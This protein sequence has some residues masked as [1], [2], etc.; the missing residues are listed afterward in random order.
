MVSPSTGAWGYICGAPTL[1]VRMP[2]NLAHTG[3]SIHP[4]VFAH[5]GPER[6]EA[7]RGH[8]LAHPSA[9]G[10]LAHISAPRALE[11]GASTQRNKMRHV[12]S[13][14]NVIRLLRIHCRHVRENEQYAS[15]TPHRPPRSKTSSRIPC[16]STHLHARRLQ[17]QKHPR[18]CISAHRD[19]HPSR[20]THTSRSR[21]T[22]S[23]HALL[24]RVRPNHLPSPHRERLR[25]RTASNTRRGDR[26]PNHRPRRRPHE[27]FVVDRVHLPVEDG[28]RSTM[29]RS[30][31]Q[32]ARKPHTSGCARHLHVRHNRGHRTR[33]PLH[34][35]DGSSSASHPSP[36]RSFLPR[37]W[38]LE[39][40]ARHTHRFDAPM[41][42][43][44]TQGLRGYTNT[45]LHAHHPP[46]PALSGAI[47]LEG[48]LLGV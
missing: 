7:R 37:E 42:R 30:C 8:S 22:S 39:L 46:A 13:T 21:P 23:L 6:S 24:H 47:R 11:H 20:R 45:H 1:T 26:R 41:Q 27:S 17:A 16:A 9:K 4:Q 3:H 5:G 34:A 14:S 19:T 31:T 33:H 12:T 10:H 36:R 25:G 28:S 44:P 29:Q 40:R 38:T 48:R 18:G 32:R 2:H 43:I 15:T 35:P